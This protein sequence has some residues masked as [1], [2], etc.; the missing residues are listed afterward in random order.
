MTIAPLNS[1]DAERIAIEDTQKWL[2]EAVIGLNLC[3]FAK[4]VVLK[5]KV[6]Y[7]V[8]LSS[9]SQDFLQIL[10]KKHPITTNFICWI[11]PIRSTSKTEK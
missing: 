6:R 7:R 10:A 1:F 11:P 9:G 3:P 2:M 4:A 8:C 5:D